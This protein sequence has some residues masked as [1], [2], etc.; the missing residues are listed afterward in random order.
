MKRS[1]IL[2]TVYQNLHNFLG[3]L[4]S[5]T[6]K[7]SKR[8]GLEKP[9]IY[10]TVLIL[11]TALFFGFSFI[12][13]I[14]P[15]G[16]PG[17]LPHQYLYVLVPPSL[18]GM[19]YVFS[20]CSKILEGFGMRQWSPI[21]PTIFISLMVI[22]SLLDFYLGVKVINQVF[23]FLL[24]CGSLALYFL[25]LRL[26]FPI[27]HIESKVA[28]YLHINQV[29]SILYLAFFV[30]LLFWSLLMASTV[31]LLA[32]ITVYHE[33]HPELLNAPLKVPDNAYPANSIE[34]VTRWEAFIKMDKKEMAEK[35][36][37]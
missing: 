2:Q 3:F 6:F 1:S 28:F 23:I 22:T 33:A 15:F 8:V 34:D 32:A 30:V 26:R 17:L 4:A 21:F 5:L 18:V 37:K 36:E 16:G 7:T 24:F 12:K 9:V 19:W 14:I 31:A 20:V 11:V 13:M 27:E 25:F 35:S 29:V 10:F